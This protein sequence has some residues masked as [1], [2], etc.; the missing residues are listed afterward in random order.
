MDLL[1]QILQAARIRGSVLA[2]IECSAPWRIDME[3]GQG[4][5]FH[6]ASVGGC[7]FEEEKNGRKSVQQGTL[8]ISTRWTEHSL[9]SHY[10]ANNEKISDVLRRFGYEPWND[11]I[12]K[13]PITIRTGGAVDC[14]ILSGVMRINAAVHDFLVRDLPD[15]IFI[16]TN[17]DNSLRHTLN[18]A[19]EIVSTEGINQQDGYG[20]LAEKLAEILFIQI[21]R[22]IALHKSGYIG[23]FI[24]V[25]K[26]HIRR[27]LF[28][29]HGDPSRA[30][31]M[32]RLSAIA[33]QSRTLFSIDFRDS[34]GLTP[35]KYVEWWRM[36]L[37]QNMLS[38]TAMGIGEIAGELGY[39]S[40]FAFSRAFKRLFGESPSEFKAK[41]L[42]A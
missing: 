4:I 17:S 38:E 37:A 3:S 18:M 20:S 1:S 23:K 13:H 19:V 27:V 12:F 21:V 39:G 11:G 31:S 34:V 35:A 7:L 29:I 33:G 42:T 2:E 26:E 5:P 30:W 28:S 9:C 6:Y 16:D 24:G 10:E 41:Y 25:G 40:Q 32:E 22:A 8:I 36:L 15:F 14:R